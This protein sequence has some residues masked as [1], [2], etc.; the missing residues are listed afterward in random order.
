MRG[1]YLTP[2]QHIG[3]VKFR[4]TITASTTVFKISI[5]QLKYT[6][7]I[8]FPVGPC[9][10]QI[11][12]RLRY[13]PYKE[14]GLADFPDLTLFRAFLSSWTIGMFFKIGS[15]AQKMYKMI[16]RWNTVNTFDLIQHVEAASKKSS[17]P[18][19][20]IVRIDPPAI[21]NKTVT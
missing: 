2:P 5:K 20:S 3:S 14:N 1:A 13:S 4:K 9:A 11:G 8:V 15:G 19:N 6:Y 10:F 21:F 7:R 18:D 16:L 17:W 12:G